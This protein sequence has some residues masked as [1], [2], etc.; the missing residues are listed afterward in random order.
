MST[1]KVVPDGIRTEAV[2]VVL[3]DVPLLVLGVVR[4][5]GGVVTAGGG[6]SSTGYGL[7]P[8]IEVVSVMDSVSLSTF[9]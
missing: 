2:E 8:I 4:E 3:V 5:G 9:F 6:V 7:S 1:S